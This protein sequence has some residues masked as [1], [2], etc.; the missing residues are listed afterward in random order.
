MRVLK[1]IFK[2]MLR[3]KLRTI[4]TIVGIA[5]AVMAF[6]LMRTVISAWNAGVEASLPYMDSL[7]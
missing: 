4:L 5:I 3:H 2:N 1:L 7:E 6:N